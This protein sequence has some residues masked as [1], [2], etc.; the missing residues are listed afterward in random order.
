MRV[1]MPYEFHDDIKRVV[2]SYLRR[3]G[4]GISHVNGT[5]VLSR[6]K[7]NI[8]ILESAYRDRAIDISADGSIKIC[9]ESIS[10]GLDIPRIRRRIEEHLR[11]SSTPGDII[12]MATKL[13]VK[14][15]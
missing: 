5:Y 13:G 2:I 7:I 12:C 14:L 4:Q 6:G 11:T 8:P 3:T 10:S 15:R 1:A 9:H